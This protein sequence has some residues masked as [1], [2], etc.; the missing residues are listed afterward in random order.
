MEQAPVWLSYASPV[1][2]LFALAVSGGTYWRQSPRVRAKVA[3]TAGPKGKIYGADKYFLDIKVHNKGFLIPVNVRSLKIV[4]REGGRSQVSPDLETAT[5]I[6][7]PEP[8]KVVGPRQSED[9]RYD[10]TDWANSGIE[11]LFDDPG[12][13]PPSV[14]E[15]LSK[16]RADEVVTIELSNGKTLTKRISVP[17]TPSR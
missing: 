13:G 16:I 1:I 2:A 15:T 6:A 4:K 12:Q 8:R 9:W 3:I 10:A 17:K 11:D 14:A 5:P 7:E